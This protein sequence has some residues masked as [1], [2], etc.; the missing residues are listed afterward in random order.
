MNRDPNAVSPSPSPSSMVALRLE[1]ARRLGCTIH[2]LDDETGYLNE[3]RQG[4]KR[5]V[6]LG[7]FSPLNNA[8]AARIATDKCHA[9]TILRHR[10]FRV[11]DGARALQPGRF[12]HESFPGHTG[13]DAARRFAE[14]IGYPVVVKPNHGARGRDVVMADDDA[15][16]VT[17]I[18]QVWRRDFLALIQEPITGY[19]VRLDFADGNF[20]FGYTRQ[21]VHLAGDGTRTL[22]ELLADADTRFADR[23]FQEGLT[24]DPIWT[25]VTQRHGLTL[26]DVVET[27]LSLDF[28]NPILNLNRL[29][30]A[31]RV[32]SPPQAWIDHGLAIGNALDL[33]HFGIDFKAEGIASDPEDATVI[34]VNASPSLAH[35][36]RMG[37]YEATIEAEMTIVAAALADC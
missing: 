10:G 37:H 4:D 7:A 27:G 12:A 25:H 22:R 29:C 28:D 14:R 26:D 31:Q 34:E 3:V 23:L 1:A 20:V 35:M 17:A 32:V 24:D 5:L 19:D 13:L 11:P 9:A 2:P 15:T 30:V 36:S 16:L 6:L 33:C 18:E 21:P 8:N